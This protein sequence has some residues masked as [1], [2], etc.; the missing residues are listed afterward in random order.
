[1]K[2]FLSKLFVFTLPILSYF[3]LLECIVKTIPNSYSY[4]YNYVIN[5]GKEINA[6]AIGHS[7]L[8]DGFC[9][10]SFF[11]KSFNLCNSAQSY[12]DDYYI[13]KELLPYMPN[14]QLVIIPIGYMNV[15]TK[16]NSD[17]V[18]NDRSIFYYEYMNV[19]YDG[20]LPL[21]YKY[22]ICSPQRAISKVISYYLK[23]E[24]IIGCDS[25]GMR[26]THHLKN[27]VNELGFGHLDLHYAKNIHSNFHLSGEDYLLK[28]IEFVHK[29]N[30]K[31]IL[32]SPPYYWK[33]FSTINYAQKEYI[34]KYTNNLCAKYSIK[35]LN[36]ENDTS[37]VNDD[38]FDETHL[39]ELGAEKFTKK[40]NDSLEFGF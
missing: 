37:F 19:N 22:E 23:K 31:I 6:V 3:V 32:V 13:L 29:N 9:P 21:K 14:L 15:S 18:F 8:Y 7:Q 5:N 12:Q 40:L 35:Y 10:D 33:C 36:M 1:M 4:K 20:K 17:V 24:D 30:V 38:F 11:M 34:E 16:T 28:I 27:R 39:S 25:M 26:S 2:K